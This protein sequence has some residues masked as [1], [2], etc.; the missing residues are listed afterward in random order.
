M[1][2]FKV[3]W[4]KSLKSLKSQSESLDNTKAFLPHAEHGL[5]EPRSGKAKL[6]TGQIPA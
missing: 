1:E 5:L 2:T 6:M 3:S 4:M